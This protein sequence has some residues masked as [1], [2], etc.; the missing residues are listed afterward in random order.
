M[1]EMRLPDQAPLPPKSPEPPPGQGSLI[2]GIL[3]AWVTFLVGEAVCA[4]AGPAAWCLPP[5][6]IL[7][8]GIV[9]INGNK[10]RTGKGLLLG[11]A[12]IF[13]VALLLVAACFGILSHSSFE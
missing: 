11:L 2:A 6:G 9:L 4:Q 1:S 10:P 12:S 13:A 3:L 8:W 5:A 7:V